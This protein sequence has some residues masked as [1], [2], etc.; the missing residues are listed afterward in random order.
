MKNF[1]RKTLLNLTLFLILPVLFFSCEKSE[2]IVKIDLNSTGWFGS[3]NTSTIPENV[4]NPFQG[5]PSTLPT[6]VDLSQYFPPIGDQGQ[7][8]TC[9]AW[10]TAYNAKSAIE[11]IKF[12][13]TPSDLQKPGYQMSAKYLF[14]AL[15]SDKKGADCN[16]TDFTPALDILLSKGVA[17]KATVPYLNLGNCSETNLDPSWNTDAARHKIKYYRRIDNSINSIKQA[18]ADKM[19]VILGAKLD[20]SFMQWNSESVYQ[21][22]TGTDQVGIHSYHAMCIVG[23]DNNK[24]PRG[25]FKVVNSWG[26]QWGANGFVWVDYNFMINGFSFNQNFFI[27]VNDEQ[28]PNP[29]D[30]DPVVTSGVDLAA[31]VDSESLLNDPTK[32][33]TWRAMDFDIYNVGNQTAQSSSEW[34][35]AYLYYDAFDANNYGILFYDRFKNSGPL[36]TPVFEKTDD[37]TNSY[38]FTI[39]S[40]IPAGKKLSDQLFTGTGIRRTYPM[41]PNLNGYF[42]LVLA[43]DATDKFQE[44]DENDNLF[45]TTDQEPKFFQ[46]G[47]GSRQNTEADNFK[48]FLTKTSIRSKEV[49]QFRTAVKPKNRNAYTPQEIIGFLKNEAKSGRLS[50]K[51][52]EAKSANSISGAKLI[53]AK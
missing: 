27:A 3:D 32:D 16:G 37:A 51:I 44:Q 24:G 7:Y 34:G 11:A 28:K 42:Y 10:A 15:P 6:S 49:E 5:D 33:N 1:H 29:A 46:N 40:N 52:A 39:N 23:Y 26:S 20:D 4:S 22:A 35:Y 13:L 18:L 53:S 30:P 43:V 14:T 45:Y 48:N 47:V 19:P 12:G 2:D 25:A 21:F 8:G 41:K 50:R 36:N 17:T 9:V 38:G 31:W